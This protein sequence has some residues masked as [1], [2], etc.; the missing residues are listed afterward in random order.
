MSISNFN[1]KLTS[2]INDLQ[3]TAKISEKIISAFT[4]SGTGINMYYSSL[5]FTDCTADIYLTN[6]NIINSLSA[7]T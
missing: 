4:L 1:E 5:C 3:D 2:I 7:F 6:L